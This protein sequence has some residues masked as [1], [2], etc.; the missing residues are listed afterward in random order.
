M[1]LSILSNTGTYQT[2]HNFD[3]KDEEMGK[4]KEGFYT[5]FILF[6]YRY[7]NCKNPASVFSQIEAFDNSRHCNN[8][9]IKSGFL[10]EY[11]V[12]ETINSI[13]LMCDY[14]INFDPNILKETEEFDKARFVRGI[15]VAKENARKIKDQIINNKVEIEFEYTDP[16]R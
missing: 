4:D 1:K 14:I 11:D 9:L 7:K 8:F 6:L 3:F 2:Y 15:P 16:F 13:G 12:K 10:A 5:T